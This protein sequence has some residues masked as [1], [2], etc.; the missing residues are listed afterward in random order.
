MQPKDQA[1]ARELA[2]KGAKAAVCDS[3]DVSL[4][5]PPR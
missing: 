3:L 5:T 4:R 2:A 1:T